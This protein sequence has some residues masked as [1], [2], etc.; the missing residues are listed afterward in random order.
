MRTASS[1]F[2]GGLTLVAGLAGHVCA[3]QNNVR[4][5]DPTAQE[6]N[7]DMLGAAGDGIT[8][9]STAI[10][11]AIQQLSDGQKL[12]FSPGKTYLL[13]KTLTVRK[14]GVKLYG[15][16][17]TLFF[18]VT[19]EEMAGKPGTAQIAILLLAP[20]TGMYGFTIRS[21]LK[22]RL[23]GHPNTYSIYLASDGQEAIDNTVEYTL[24]GILAEKATNFLISR[25]TIRRTFADGIHVTNGSY[26]GR[27]T[28]NTVR[29]TGDDMIAVVSYGTG[30]PRCGDV[31]I[32]DNDVSGNYSGRGITV[33]G[34]QDVTIRRNNVSYTTHGAG[35]LINADVYWHTSNPGNTL[36]EDNI[37]SHVQ[38]TEAV[39]NPINMHQ[40]TGQGA[41]DIDGQG[42]KMVHHVLVRNNTITDA[43]IGIQ[44]RG[45]ACSI[46]LAGNKVT[47]VSKPIAIA[48]RRSTECNVACS[49]NTLDSNQISIPLCTG[50]MPIVTGSKLE[51]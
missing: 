32:E 7:V 40:K 3:A 34:G 25:N 43:K 8:D 17:A 35:I 33:L 13:R 15:Y 5:A 44:M 20:R 31:L 2:L 14:P 36:I 46:G 22:R 39:Y 9:D 42:D 4:G 19:D 45:N 6:L 47:Q 30:E 18:H 21:D 29:E 51:Q 38:M 41:I 37:I 26:H 28:H 11:A 48:S 1:L 16:N 23:D 27:I 24:V 50:E 12:V 10:N 49:Q